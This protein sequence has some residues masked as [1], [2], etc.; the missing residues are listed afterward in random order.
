[1]SPLMSPSINALSSHM[2]GT[3]P[4]P[5]C[6]RPRE[7]PDTVGATFFN[8]CKTNVRQFFVYQENEKN[9][10]GKPPQNN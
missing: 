8:V 3:N 9:N 2:G 1:M 10:F 5:M 4:P 6:K 7:N